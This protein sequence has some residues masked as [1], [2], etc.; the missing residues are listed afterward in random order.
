M[1]VPLLALGAGAFVIYLATRAPKPSDPG[2]PVSPEEQAMRQQVATA[3]DSLL[4][5][6]SDPN[7][8]DTVA[9]AIE[10]Y[11]FKEEANR[12]RARAN[13]LRTQAA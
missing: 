9:N 11:G 5:T 12:L 7:G 10:P 1:L 2:R 8:M 3:V 4:K 6:G 13:E